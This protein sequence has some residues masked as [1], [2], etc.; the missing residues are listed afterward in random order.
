MDIRKPRP[1]T[2]DPYTVIDQHYLILAAVGFLA[3]LIDGALGMAFGILSTTS[4]MTLGVA[5]ATASSIVHTAEVFTSGANALSHHYYRNINWRLVRRLGVTGVAGAI[6]GAA[7]LSYVGNTTWI[8]PLI[9][10]YLS[11]LGLYILFRAAHL[12]PTC[13][14][15][16]PWTPIVGFVAGF[17]DT[18]GGGGWGPVSTTTLVGSGHTP[19]ST[20]AS[21]NTTEFF[22]TLSASATF[23]FTL[24][25]V[26]W[27]EVLAFLIGGL[28]AAPLG[29]YIVR[30]M[31]RRALMIMVGVLVILVSAFQIA[32][33]MLWV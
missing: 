21:V 28:L 25:M 26:P 14:D 18:S 3:Q 23:V 19:A 29:G 31:P 9:F 24:G 10:T 17:L 15:P 2:G 5:P 33:Y 22:I 4:L 7:T 6:L 32:K 11:L 8:R 12:T 30:Y 1:I 13:D 16:K 27:K 20:I